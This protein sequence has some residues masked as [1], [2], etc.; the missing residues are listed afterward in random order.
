MDSRQSRI[1]I[2]F[3]EKV[4]DGKY[5]V[6]I[7]SKYPGLTSQSMKGVFIDPNT[8]P[9][10]RKLIEK[11][12]WFTGFSFSVGITPGYD[13]FRGVPTVVLGGTMGY[14]IYQW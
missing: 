11:R 2:T 3:G 13:V 5:N 14:T 4:E 12:H 9:E 6:Y 7:T 1:N 10:I 8:N